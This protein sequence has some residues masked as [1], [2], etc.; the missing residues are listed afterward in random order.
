M[1]EVNKNVWGFFTTV[2]LKT[3]TIIAIW[4]LQKKKGFGQF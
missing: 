2:P 3:S 4:C 1:L